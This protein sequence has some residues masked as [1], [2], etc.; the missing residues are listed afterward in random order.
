MN[1]FSTNGWS[2]AR[3]VSKQAWLSRDRRLLAATNLIYV[4][5]HVRHSHAGV[6]YEIN[7]RK[8]YKT[9]IFHKMAP[10]FTPPLSARGSLPRIG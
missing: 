1:V 3:I 2:V 8:A 7:R 5:R 4:K 10:V 6:G 9:S